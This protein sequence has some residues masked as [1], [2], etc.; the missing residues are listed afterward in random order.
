MDKTD[1]IRAIQGLL[2][3]YVNAKRPLGDD[4]ERQVVT[5]A[6]KVLRELHGS[7]PKT[8]VAPAGH[9]VENSEL[10]MDA[11]YYL[12]RGDHYDTG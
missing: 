10:Q 7:G 11:D 2:N 6:E 4:Q 5:F 12:G 1:I 9:A 3:Y 8:T